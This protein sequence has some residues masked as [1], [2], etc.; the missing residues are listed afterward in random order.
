MA[1]P[2][3]YEQVS[4]NSPDGAQ[5]GKT[6]TDLISFYGA[7]P[8]TRPWTAATNQVSTN[9]TYSISTAGIANIGWGVSTQQEMVDIIAAI[10]TVQYTLKQL[11]IIAS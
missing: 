8:V 11:G 7:T 5:F 4:Y 1:Q 10:S 9:S 3:E 6:S 2:T